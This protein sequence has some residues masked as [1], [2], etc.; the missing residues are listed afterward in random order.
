MEIVGE[1]EVRDQEKEGSMHE[2]LNREPQIV[3][4][5]VGDRLIKALIS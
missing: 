4:L 1:Y 5:C 3:T 2:D